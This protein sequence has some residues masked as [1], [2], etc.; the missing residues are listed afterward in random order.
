MKIWCK[1]CKEYFDSVT[2]DPK[3][4]WEFDNNESRL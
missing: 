4:N 1:D 3:H 2:H